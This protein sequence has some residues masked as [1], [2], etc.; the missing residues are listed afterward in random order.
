[1]KAAQ[2][3]RRVECRIIFEPCVACDCDTSH[4]SR[5]GQRKI[6][7][8]KSSRTFEGSVSDP[9][10]G[11][12]LDDGGTSSLMPGGLGGSGNASVVSRDTRTTIQTA[13]IT[14]ICIASDRKK[15]MWF[16]NQFDSDMVKVNLQL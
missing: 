13:P 15:A 14:A 7:S 6:G 10:A 8:E 5:K 1:M 11:L 3:C 4:S 9:I 12:G 2:D 16:D